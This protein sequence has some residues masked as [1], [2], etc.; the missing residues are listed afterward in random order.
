MPFT[1]KVVLITGA[2]S[3]IG[4]GTAL[5]FLQLGAQLSLAGRDAQNLDAFAE[6]C[7]STKMLTM[8]GDLTDEGEPERIIDCTIKHFGK[9]DVLVNNAGIL[10]NGSIENTSL[11]QYDRY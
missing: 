8:T 4:A 5:H 3:G 2:C 1:G 9:L 6:K 11:K 7:K 10:E